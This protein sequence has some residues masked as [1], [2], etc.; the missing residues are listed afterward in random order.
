ML[1]ALKAGCLILIVL[2]PVLGKWQSPGERVPL[3]DKG[4][5]TLYVQCRAGSLD[6]GDFMLDTGSGYVTL[7]ESSLGKLRAAGEVSYVKNIRGRLANGEEQVVPVWRINRLVI[8]EKCVLH[9][10]EAAV[11]PGKAREILGL[12]ALKK[13][14]PFTIS[15]DP[16]S[17]LLQKC[18]DA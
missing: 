10:V 17:L 11:F 5:S 16:P 1:S 2:L 9:D 6:Q 15:M 3:S 8:A 14:A 13:M 12:S 4:Y 7:N 18:S